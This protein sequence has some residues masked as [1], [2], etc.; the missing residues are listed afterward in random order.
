MGNSLFQYAYIYAQMRDGIIPDIYLQDVKYFDKYREEIQKLF[1]EGIGSVPYVSIH[2][3][4]GDYVNHPFYVDLCKTDY[5]ER[6]IKLFPKSK[7]LVFSDDPEF[8]RSKFSNENKF[9]IM[10]GGDEL[11]DLN[12]MASCESNII[13]NSSYSFWAAYL[14]HNKGKKVIY[15]KQWFSDGIQRVGYPKDWIPM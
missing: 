15:P 13:A 3:R 2:V 4:R 14:N 11:E 1:G 7:F 8:V 12:M 6:A 10:E 9:Q 5:Y